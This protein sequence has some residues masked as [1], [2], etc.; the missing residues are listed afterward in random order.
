MPADTFVM[1]GGTLAHGTKKAT[2]GDIPVS[3]VGKGTRINLIANENFDNMPNYR[4]ATDIAEEAGNGQLVHT[5]VVYEEALRSLP[6]GI[7]LIN[8]RKVIKQ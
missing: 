6:R 4:H 1:K 5:K 2:L 3:V 7:Y 8:G